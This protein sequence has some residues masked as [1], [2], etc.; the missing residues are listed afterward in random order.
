MEYF[1]MLAVL[2]VFALIFWFVKFDD[3]A[4]PPPPAPTP[5]NPPRDNGEVSEDNPA[6]P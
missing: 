6:K 1:A 2:I 4:V 5:P 3:N